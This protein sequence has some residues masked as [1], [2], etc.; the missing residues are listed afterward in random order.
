M[1]KAGLVGYIAGGALTLSSIG[2]IRYVGNEVKEL[3]SKT[4]SEYTEEDNSQIKKYVRANQGCSKACSAGYSLTVLSFTTLTAGGV[5]IAVDGY[6][7]KR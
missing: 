2:G 3:Q 1:F 6:R 4:H 7:K 5:L